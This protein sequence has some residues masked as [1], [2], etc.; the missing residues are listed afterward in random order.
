MEYCDNGDL[1]DFIE[2]Q[3]L[4]KHLLHENYNKLITI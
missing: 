2:R 1:N 3:K 4:T